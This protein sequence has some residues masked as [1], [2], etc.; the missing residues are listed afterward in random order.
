MLSLADLA[1]SAETVVAEA[2]ARLV[3][4]QDQPL[5]TERKDLLDI[6]TEADLAAE[7]IVIAGLKKLTPEAGFLA[8]ESGASQSA[9]NSSPADGHMMVSC[10][11]DSLNW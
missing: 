6:V 11:S 3:A 5:R 4:M 10:W 1:A 9:M 7:A 8:E 2:A